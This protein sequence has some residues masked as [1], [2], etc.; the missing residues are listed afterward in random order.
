MLRLG[1]LVVL[2]GL[3]APSN[4]FAQSVFLGDRCGPPLTPCLTTGMP[5]ADA[6]RPV[7]LVAPD[8]RD[9]CLCVPGDVDLG[10]PALCCS[11]TGA[12]ACPMGSTCANIDGTPV[13]VCA[14]AT[15]EFCGTMPLTREGVIACFTAPGATVANAY[16]DLGDCDRD[17]RPNGTEVGSTNPCCDEDTDFDC[18][19]TA[20]GDAARCCAATASDP[21]AC[22]LSA[23]AEP[24][25]CCASDP[26]GC[27]EATSDP[28][29]CCLA[30]GG[31][32]LDC[33]HFSPT[34]GACCFANGGETALCCELALDDE[35]F[36]ECS[37]AGVPDAGSSP[38]DASGPQDAA[39]SLDASNAE[40]AGVAFDGGVGADASQGLDAS[41][42]GFGGGGGCRCSA[43]GHSR[44]TPWMLL[45]GALAIAIPAYRRRR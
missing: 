21:A 7:D 26:I 13:D 4:S 32:A 34:P 3:V 35:T 8:G 19:M 36:P 43:Q 41:S 40:D 31:D 28:E 24:G 6:F 2:F 12:G 5:C 39:S 17:G 29:A 11:A 22:C 38:L 44:P 37:D 14:D 45:L 42:I 23:G 9:I 33:C 27:C 30:A 1:C 10:P 18:C 15:M 16:W 25:L 20:F